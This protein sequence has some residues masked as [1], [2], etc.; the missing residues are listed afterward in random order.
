MGLR[1]SFTLVD[2][3]QFPR[4]ECHQRF[5]TKRD[6]FQIFRILRV[7]PAHGLGIRRFPT[8]KFLRT[9]H[10]IRW[11]TLGK[12]LNQ[13]LLHQ[14]DMAATPQR[15]LHRSV[16]GGYGFLSFLLAEPLPRHVVKRATRK[17]NSPVG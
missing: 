10:L 9:D 15:L 17:G 16:A 6:D 3:P 12:R 14:S 8:A 2:I 1:C 4:R 5:C 7:N 11:E 13:R